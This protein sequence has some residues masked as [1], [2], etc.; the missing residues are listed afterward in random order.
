MS[1]LYLVK[2][3]ITQ[4]QLTA[5]AV[6]SVEPIVPDFAESCSMFAPFPI[7][8]KILLAVFWQKIFYIPMGFIKNSSVNFNM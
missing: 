7:C 5:Y 6:H 4:K 2:L 8:S 1:S 3:K